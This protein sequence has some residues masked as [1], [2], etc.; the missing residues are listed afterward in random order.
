M[1]K[2]SKFDEWIDQRS[3]RISIFKSHT[4]ISSNS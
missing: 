3:S 2:S 4:Y 1:G